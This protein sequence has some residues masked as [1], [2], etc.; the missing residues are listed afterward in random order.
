[1]CLMLVNPICFLWNESWT[2]I[3]T[4]CL[5]SC[6]YPPYIVS[7]KLF[8]S[9]NF[10][11][12]VNEQ[13]KGLEIDKLTS[14]IQKYKKRIKTYKNY[15]IVLNYISESLIDQRNVFLIGIDLSSISFSIAN[16]SYLTMTSSLGVADYPSMLS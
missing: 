15:V 3:L 7:N 12:I 8:K 10:T 16:W 9:S 6:V 1:M 5:I 11:L 13:K 2:N 4:Y 14:V